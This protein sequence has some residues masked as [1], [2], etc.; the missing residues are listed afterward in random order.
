MGAVYWYYCR[1]CKFSVQSEGP[2]S[3]GF[4]YEGKCFKCEECGNIRDLATKQSDFNTDEWW[5]V[6]P[7]C[8]KCKSKNVIEWDFKCPKCDIKMSRKRHAHIM[9]D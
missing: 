6:T 8:G 1:K 4:I 5:D 7:V 2:T 9:E 3:M